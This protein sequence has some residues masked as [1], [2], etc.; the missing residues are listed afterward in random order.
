M[1][2]AMGIILG[3]IAYL[4]IGAYITGLLVRFKWMS[5]YDIDNGFSVP[6]T[7][8]WP[9]VFLFIICRYSFYLGKGNNDK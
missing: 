6:V 9:L 1:V 4:F 3:I 2:T 8:F 5:K 7:V